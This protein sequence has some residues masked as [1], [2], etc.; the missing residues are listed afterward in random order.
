MLKRIIIL[1]LIIGS[2]LSLAQSDSLDNCISK[3]DSISGNRIYIMSDVEPEFSGGN[4]E[5]LRFVQKN[6]DYKIDEIFVSTVYIEF[7]IE[8]DGRIT[9]IGIVYGRNEDLN[10]AMIEVFKIMPNWKPAEC[11]GIKVAYHMVLPITIKLG[12]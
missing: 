4:A 12:P 7:V 3:I 11:N 8:P 1:I 6:L 10:N 9:N 5:M 2:K